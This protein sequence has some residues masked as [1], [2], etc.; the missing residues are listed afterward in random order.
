MGLRPTLQDS[1][2]RNSKPSSCEVVHTIKR[3]VVYQETDGS[4]EEVLII[5]F[6]KS[7]SR[8]L[9]KLQTDRQPEVEPKLR[10][11]RKSSQSA[12]DLL[13][14]KVKQ[15]PGQASSATSAADPPKNAETTE[16][17]VGGLAWTATEDDVYNLFAA[18]GDI[19]EVK[20]LHN[21]QG[22]SKGSGFV[23]FTSPA[24]AQGALKANGAELLGRCVRVSQASEKPVRGPLGE[25]LGSTVYV[26]NLSYAI[27]EDSITSF[28][29]ECGEIKEVRI[30]KDGEGNSRG[31]AH[32]DFTTQSATEAAVQMSGHRLEG[33]LITIDYA[34]GKTESQPPAALTGDYTLRPT[35]GAEG[36]PKDKLKKTGAIQRF[37]GIKMA[38]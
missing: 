34:R 27:T 35:P 38:L 26:R 19:L 15:A 17:F 25:A 6:T 20:L 7:P 8:R 13:Q 14:K 28:F 5:K 32:V 12:A 36:R 31:F 16:V 21:D 29:A 4:D 10:A 11:K 24:E 23:R 37:A 22:K 9:A 1:S 18:Y 33:R 3:R 30:A 2:A